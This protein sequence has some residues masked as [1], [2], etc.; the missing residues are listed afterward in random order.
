[1]KPPHQRPVMFLTPHSLTFIR[2]CAAASS[3]V[4]GLL[5]GM[6]FGLLRHAHA[7]PAGCCAAFLLTIVWLSISLAVWLAARPCPSADLALRLR[8]NAP[9]RRGTDESLTT[10]SDLRSQR[11]ATLDLQNIILTP[12]DAP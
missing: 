8:A 6:S 12:D 5:A 10:A 4:H 2:R 7:A 1:M 3:L 11:Q 9:R